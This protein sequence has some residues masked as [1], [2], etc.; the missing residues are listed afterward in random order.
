MT[1]VLVNKLHSVFGMSIVRAVL[2]TAF[3]SVCLSVR[4]SVRHTLVCGGTTLCAARVK[5]SCWRN[6]RSA[7]MPLSLSVI[8]VTY[9]A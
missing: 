6:A 7:T 4:L 9:G 8:L 5:R 1:G 3:L 2:A